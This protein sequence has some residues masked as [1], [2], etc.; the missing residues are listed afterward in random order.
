MLVRPKSDFGTFVSVCIGLGFASVVVP[1]ASGDEVV[2]ESI[3]DNTIFTDGVD[4]PAE[5]SN[6]AG[7]HIFVGR[8][9]FNGLRRGLIAF[10][11]AGSL[12]QDAVVEEAAL[13]LH[14]SLGTSAETAYMIHRLASDWGE[15]TSNSG[16]GA[17]GSATG[18]G[19]G[20]PATPGDATWMH[21][22][23]D[24]Q[25]W[26]TPGGDFAPMPSGQAMIG[27]LADDYV[28]ESTPQMVADVQ[29]WLEAPGGNF[30]WLIKNDEPPALQGRAK[31]FDSREHPNPAFHPRLRIRYSM[32]P[33]VEEVAIDASKDNT[34]FADEFGPRE[35]S[36]GAGPH[37]FS[38]KTLFQGPRRGLLAFDVASG[39]PA[40]ATIVEAE[41]ILHMSLGTQG[42]Y[43]FALHRLLADWG[44]GTSNSSTG[45]MGSGNGGGMG[46][47]A[48][49]G[50]ATWEYRSYPDVAWGQLG[51]DFDAMESSIARVGLDTAYYTWG[52]TPRM[53]DDVQRWLD[54]ASSNFGWILIGDVPVGATRTA[55]RFDSREH[56]NSAFWPQ[57]IVRYTAPAGPACNT[58]PADID[59]SGRVNGADIQGFVRCLLSGSIMDP[60]CACA[61][62]DNDSALSMPD[63]VDFVA[64]VSQSID[65]DAP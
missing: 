28:W 18:G 45:P 47:S 13:T 24:T 21:T 19:A 59:G 15:G 48:T 64:T 20:A 9:L 10:D 22:F 46:A 63:V 25:Q 12:P 26:T 8:T 34:M 36:N 65:C 52:S 4:D 38:G 49:A 27:P 50:D 37:I 58:C 29:S 31:R 33:P 14:M 5:L 7:P 60:G 51:G 23:F 62:M 56:P 55:K 41:L 35:L 53:V 39:V 6:G 11:V 32:P 61:D 44:E 54:D 43:D 3:R 1:R 30:G 16:S 2:L 17:I 40:G 42:D 57:L